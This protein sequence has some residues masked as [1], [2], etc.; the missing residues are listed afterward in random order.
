MPRIDVPWTEPVTVEHM[1]AA[2]P[3]D[4]G[5]AVASHSGRRKLAAFGECSTCD[6]YRVSLGRSNFH[7]AHDAM[8]GCRSGKRPHCTCDGCF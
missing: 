4:D 5:A 6:H 1:L 8:G 3:D 7:P 2:D